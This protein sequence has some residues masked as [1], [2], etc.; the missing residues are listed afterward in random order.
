MVG[1]ALNLV[2]AAVLIGILV[3][4]AGSVVDTS[5]DRAAENQLE[6]IGN[7]VAAD[8]AGADR[9]VNAADG[10]GDP[11]VSVRVELPRRVAGEQYRMAFDDDG[12]TLMAS[13]VTVRVGFAATT[14]D[15]TETEI[16]GGDVVI[17]Y[18]T[19]TDRLEVASA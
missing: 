15:V 12:V 3:G 1:Y 11:T 13:D 14:T 8:V 10:S 2:I 17:R 6:V 16:A 4:A 9:M 18:D 7:Q 19:A 5:T